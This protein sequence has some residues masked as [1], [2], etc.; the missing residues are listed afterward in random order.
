MDEAAAEI[1]IFRYF[2]II[3]INLKENIMNI[4]LIKLKN[5]KY[6]KIRIFQ[7]ALYYFRRAILK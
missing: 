5:V 2:V 7:T 6:I 4:A 3:V 1:Y